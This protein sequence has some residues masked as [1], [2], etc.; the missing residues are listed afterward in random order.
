VVESKGLRLL[1]ID[2]AVQAAVPVGGAAAPAD[3]MVQLLHQVRPGAKTALVIGLGSGQT[4]SQLAEYG[5]DVTA[6]ELEPIVI[7]Y[8]HKY[9]GYRGKAVASEGLEY[10]ND[11]RDQY[12]IVLLDAFGGSRPP[13]TLMASD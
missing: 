6:V 7:E 9:F 12:D 4:A 8:A 3:P 13:P 1:V 2:G 5:V 10:L 11:S